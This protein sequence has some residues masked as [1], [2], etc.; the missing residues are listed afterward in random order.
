M[1]HLKYVIIQKK[2]KKKRNGGKK[3]ETYRKLKLTWQMKI[4]PYKK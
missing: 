1:S 3:I 2:A 4:Q